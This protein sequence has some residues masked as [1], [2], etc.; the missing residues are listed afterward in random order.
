MGRTSRITIGI[1]AGSGNW[2][3]P[4]LFC[5]IATGD[6][7]T[8]TPA[9]DF[10]VSRCEIHYHPAQKRLRI[11]QQIFLDDFEAALK[12]VAT[13]T[14]LRIGMP[15]EHPSA[16]SLITAYLGRKFSVQAHQQPM[17]FTL[18]GKELSEDLTAIWLYLEIP[19]DHDPE[20]LTVE[21]G[22]LFELFSDQKNILSFQVDAGR[23]QIF[24]LDPGKP[25]ID[26]KVP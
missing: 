25:R 2:I 16:D 5:L 10:H 7:F 18:M 19:V 3:I 9:H 13:D 11:S 8:A 26:I 22:V 6:A 4:L 14:T 17:P 15:G 12:K 21:F 20:T 23:P 24:L 1:K